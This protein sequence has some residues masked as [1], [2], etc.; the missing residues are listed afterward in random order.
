MI[1][2]LLTT[3]LILTGL[4]AANAQQKA[5]VYDVAQAQEYISATMNAQKSNAQPL[6]DGDT[7]GYFVNKHVARNTG[8]ASNSYYTI[9]MPYMQSGTVVPTIS[10][11]GSSFLNPGNA[12]I[13]VYGGYALCLRHAASISP[14]VA[15]R[16]YIYSATPAGVPIAK[17]DSAMTS[18]TQSTIGSW[19]NATFTTPVTVTGAFFMSYKAIVTPGDTIRYFINN[20]L[21][22]T[23][24]LTPASLRFGENLSYSRYNGSLVDTEDFFGLGT[25]H[26]NI[27]VPFVAFS[28]SAGFTA[29][30]TNTTSPTGYCANLPVTYT[31]TSA[32]ASVLENRQ[33]NFNAF[34]GAW[35][36]F[37]NTASI[38]PTRTA[39]SVYNW[40]FN[41]GTVTVA[42]A[43]VNVPTAAIQWP[44]SGNTNGNMIVKYQH[45]SM[46]GRTSKTQQ[47]SAIPTFTVV[48]CGLVGMNQNFMDMNF[49]V[50]PNPAINGKTNIDGLEGKNTITV[51]N[52]IGQV[53]STITTENEKEVIDINNQPAGTYVI[54]VT[55]SSNK[56][57]VV[58][59]IKD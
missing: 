30:P 5:K 9:K 18:V 28:Y 11:V 52:L 3:G 6:P 13:T 27:V 14:S 58:K 45:S 10:E 2:R 37:V 24:T 7:L 40:S 23:S 26:E 42:S 20:G 33:F 36:P 25:E 22:A 8:T 56:S 17:L 31:S 44:T 16:L 1:K 38:A 48:N 29:P 4:M 32:P 21:S 46:F 53:V 47:S 49:S 57:K 35:M 50:Y 55:D 19:C 43:S 54:R 15:V 34:G 12:T 39:E 51:Y 41:Q 59:I